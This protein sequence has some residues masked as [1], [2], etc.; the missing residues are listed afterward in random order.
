MSQSTFSKVKNIVVDRLDV[1]PD[2]VTLEANFQ[3]D[4][5]ADSLDCVE[6]I[7]ELEK[8]FNIEINDEV[9]EN[10]HT[11]N[12]VVEYIDKQF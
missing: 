2:E 4:L 1:D 8:E 7:M 6:L 11:V 12:D 3:E 5:G 10:L 9:A